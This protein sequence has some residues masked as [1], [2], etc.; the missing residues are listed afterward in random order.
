VRGEAGH[1]MNDAGQKDAGQKRLTGRDLVAGGRPRRPRLAHGLSADVAR[2]GIERGIL[3]HGWWQRVARAVR[4]DDRSALRWRRKAP[5]V[6]LEHGGGDGRGRG[7]GENRQAKKR[8][9]EE[10]A[11]REKKS[12]DAY[13]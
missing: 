1:E 7:R 4:P 13:G 3:L 5:A 9:V 2:E 6:G 12:S 11:R 8:P 10:L